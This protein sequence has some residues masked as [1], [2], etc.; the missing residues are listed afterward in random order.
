MTEERE[1]VLLATQAAVTFKPDYMTNDKLEAATKGHG[2]L[3]IPV[4]CAANS[5]A[6]DVFCGIGSP[7]MELL[8]RMTLVDAAAA[9]LPLDMVMEKAIQQA[10]LAG[11][12]PENAALI[13]ASLAYFTG[14]CARS[15]V[16]LGNRK[17][18]AIARMH[19]GAPRTSA[20]A[21]TTGKF[22]HKIP[23]FP[24]YL[25][26]YN[27]LMD[28]KLTRIDGAILPPFIAGGA[29][30]GHS[31]LGEDINIPEMARNTAK[32]G[33]EAM[34][35]SM[36]GAGIT[37]YPLWPALIGAAVALEMIHPDAALGEEYG[38]FGDV[39]TAYLAGKGAIEEAKL[40]PKIHVR[41]TREEYDTARVVGDFGLILKDI[42]GP[43]VI[44]SMAFEEIF[45]GFEEAA[46]IGAGFSGGPVNPPLGHVCGDCMPALRLLI[47]HGGDPY[48]VADAITAYKMNSFIDPEMALCSLNT[49]A[50][51]AET[52]SRGS[53]SHA[54]ILASEAVRDRAIYRRAVKVYE[55][56]KAGKSIEESART[57]DDERKAAVEAR[58]SAILSGFTGHKIDLK[59]TV[60]KPQGRR[61]DAFTKKY[62]AF[63][64][65]VSYDISI[66]GKPYHI[67][68][69]AAKA[70]PEFALNPK[71]RE[72][73][74][75]G[76]A[77]FAGA[78]LTQELQYI[79]HTIINVTVPA[80]VATLLGKDEKS[81]AKSA[82]SGAYLTK[83][84][85]GAKNRAFDVARL[86][87]KIYT[88]LNLPGEA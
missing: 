64:S 58:G 66:D 19:A 5:L 14:S 8:S 63:D 50:R 52:V 77:L 43:S 6:E 10:K 3:V 60:I 7:D 16:P 17:L 75:M 36:H 72:N 21:L 57:L 80:A 46:M 54:C 23:A 84:I 62:W 28:K 18:G 29:I 26:V 67:E 65:Y 82:E 79:G 59:F 35:K 56:M 13:V 70:V 83:A 39:D 22:T 68:N 81:A 1:K 49:I 42:G 71:A 41:G 24:A 37:A 15:G 34:I 51:K 48:P 20:I 27:Q 25:A 45:A 74:D 4:Y 73:P 30:Y 40:P 87:K 76:T 31:A 9:S 85:P 88:R 55:M 61:T 2:S 69:L 33:T 44:A 78:V 86:A 47:K 12:A 32:V 11:A 38:A 53:V